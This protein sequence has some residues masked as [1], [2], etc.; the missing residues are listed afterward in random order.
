MYTSRSHKIIFP[1]MFYYITIIAVTPSLE[2][3]KWTIYL[4]YVLL[5][6]FFHV[7]WF[8]VTFLSF[9]IFKIQILT[10][11]TWRQDC[12]S[13]VCSLTGLFC[14]RTFVSLAGGGRPFSS[15]RHSFHEMNFCLWLF[16]CWNL[17][18]HKCS[19]RSWKQKGLDKPLRPCKLSHVAN[20]GL[21]GKEYEDSRNVVEGAA[22]VVAAAVLPL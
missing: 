2:N 1:M 3:S 8:C 15:C 11:I 9:Y 5:K 7:I 4:K 22:A 13:V 14:A 18:L 17:L 20:W 10:K 21:A 12:S 16:F 19:E 6:K